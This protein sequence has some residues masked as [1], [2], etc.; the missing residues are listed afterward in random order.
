MI[1]MVEGV[2]GSGKTYYAVNEISNALKL[3]N[4]PIFTNINFKIPFDDLLKP[5]D[6]RDFQTF[7]KDELD[8]FNSFR[9][10]L[11]N[12]LD[13]SFDH[14]DSDS[15]DSDQDHNDSISNNYDEVLKKS[16]L[17]DKYGSALIVWDECH[18]D[19]DDRKPEFVRFLSY[20]RHFED[21][22]V[23]FITQN[24]GLI[25][26]KYKRFIDIYVFAQS[27]VKRFLS[28]VFRYKLYTSSQQFT[29]YHIKDVSLSSN[30]K[31]FSL[32]DSG[33][34]KP[35][36]SVFLQKLL[37]ILG[38]VIFLTLMYKYVIMG[39]LFHR[40]DK[41][42]DQNVTEYSIPL[43]NPDSQQL[44]PDTRTV[45]EMKQEALNNKNGDLLP[46]PPLASGGS[47]GVNGDS[48]IPSSVERHLVRFQC[49]Q[50]YCYFSGNRF[51]LSLGTMDRF[52]QEFGGKILTAEPINRDISIITAIV[53]NDLFNM[54]EAHNI[55]SGSDNYGT[56]SETNTY[57]GSS[58]VP[59]VSGTPSA[60]VPP[61]PSV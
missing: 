55:K 44:P 21:M 56:H 48:S 22:D 33:S 29:K 18:N 10:T 47:Q 14:V 46:P 27:A 23:I 52:L 38:G 58:M 54:I 13:E 57:G 16:G 59:T 36:K 39:Y 41:P 28:S 11:S 5:L 6:V 17:L 53:P 2:P 40:Y 24:L 49:T 7:C 4:R 1:Y 50:S 8:F 15:E 31:I 42:E 35:N 19:L 60:Y 30:Q 61:V 25:D 12:Q 51:T 9:E 37:P 34:Y 45:D 20:H 3:K 26:R 32:Y 43:D